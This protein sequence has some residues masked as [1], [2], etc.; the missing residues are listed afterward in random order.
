MKTF[1]K[2]FVTRNRDEV[3]RGILEMVS[4]RKDKHPPILK[5]WIEYQLQK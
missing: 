4:N 5:K 1:L 3:E 2:L